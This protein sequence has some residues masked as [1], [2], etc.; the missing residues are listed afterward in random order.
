V[1]AAGAA[2]P[3][4]AGPAAAGQGRGGQTNARANWIGLAFTR[5]EAYSR[6]A[7]S[8]PAGDARAAAFTRLS[9]IHA[10]R[11]QQELVTSAAFDA[12]WV[13]AFAVSYLVTGGGVK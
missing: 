6:L 13:G 12:P 8:L 5:A 9:D 2:A 3:S 10:E 1:P 4:G 11:G 7:L